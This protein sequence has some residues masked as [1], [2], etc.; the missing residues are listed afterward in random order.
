MAEKDKTCVFPTSPCILNVKR[1]CA[2]VIFLRNYPFGPHFNV[3]F[4]ESRVATKSV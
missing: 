2:E 3:T 1:K 4:K